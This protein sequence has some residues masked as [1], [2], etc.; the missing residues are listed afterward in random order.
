MSILIVDTKCANLASVGFAIDR[1]GITWKISD[2]PAE[3]MAAD[4]VLIPGVGSAPYAVEKIAEAGLL[5]TLKSLEQP[6]LGICLGMQ[7]LFE[8]L[9]EGG[10][11][12]DGLGLVPGQVRALETGDLPSPHMGWNRLSNL[13]DDPLT[14]GLTE[15]DHAYFVHSFAAPVS[16]MTLATTTYQN[17]FTA[18]LRH[19]NVRGCQFHP[20]RSA[21]TG[22]TI[23]KAFAIL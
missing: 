22:A 3:I 4:R 8:T 20:E 18:M 13:I 15:G 14:A 11:C 1:L 21:E 6:V 5:D 9:E 23:L 2:N 12:V 17:P 7:L 16:N 10:Q 19:G